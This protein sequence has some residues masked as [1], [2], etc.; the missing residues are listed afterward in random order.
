MFHYYI[1]KLSL[2]QNVVIAYMNNISVATPP[3]PP[4]P[5]PPTPACRVLQSI[6][7]LSHAG[8]TGQSVNWKFIILP[9]P[10]RRR[11][12][13]NALLSAYRICWKCFNYYSD[14]YFH[15]TPAASAIR[16]PAEMNFLPPP[17]PP[18]PPH[19]FKCAVLVRF[20]AGRQTPCTQ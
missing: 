8:H 11:H 14:V 10:L 6:A 5:P 13:R 3:P 20:R 19:S 12:I 4:T 1:L 7:I 18:A 16:K 15:N 9:C 2:F 17:P